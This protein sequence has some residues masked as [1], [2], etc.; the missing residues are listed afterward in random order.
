MATVKMFQGKDRRMVNKYKALGAAIT[1]RDTLALLTTKK[2]QALSTRTEV[3]P[4]SDA[5]LMSALT[6]VNAR[7]N[8]VLAMT[9]TV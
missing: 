8:A 2:T 3:F 7:L 4:A 5:A 1:T 6:L 9:K